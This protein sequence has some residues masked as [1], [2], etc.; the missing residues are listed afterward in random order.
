MLSCAMSPTVL[1]AYNVVRH[2]LL[3]LVAEQ[4]HDRLDAL[5]GAVHVVAEEDVVG[6]GREAAHLEEPQQVV[7]LP[8]HVSAD[9]D[10]TS[11]LLRCH[12]RK[13]E[14]GRQDGSA[15]KR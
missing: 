14:T 11:H 10:R 1:H 7:V 13:A 5:L 2:A 9:V 8:V 4:Q 15:T 12:I 3:E 6:A